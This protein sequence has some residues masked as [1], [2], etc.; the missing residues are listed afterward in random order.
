MPCLKAACQFM[1][2]HFISIFTIIHPYIEQLFYAFYI[3]YQNEYYY[4]PVVNAKPTE[5]ITVFYIL[6][7][8]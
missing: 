6:I 2:H 7:D 1:K 8:K 3:L 5:V 4:H